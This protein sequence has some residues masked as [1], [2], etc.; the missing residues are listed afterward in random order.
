MFDVK[1]YTIIANFVQ[2]ADLQWYIGQN[3][4]FEKKNT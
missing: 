4:I 1:K 3:L 2:I